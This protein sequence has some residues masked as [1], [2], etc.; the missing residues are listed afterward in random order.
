MDAAS[1]LW[2]LEAVRRLVLSCGDPG[3]VILTADNVRV[4]PLRPLPHNPAQPSL[5]LF[6]GNIFGKV[7]GARGGVCLRTV[8]LTSL[9]RPLACQPVMELLVRRALPS[10]WKHYR[11]PGIGSAAL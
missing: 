9:A 8:R 11:Q 4:P 2:A 6:F 3:V 10:E 1:D 7:V 5:G